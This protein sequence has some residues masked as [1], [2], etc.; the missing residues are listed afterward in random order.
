MHPGWVDT[1]ALPIAMP[2][3]YKKFKTELRT[4]E[5]GADTIVWLACKPKEELKTGEFYFDRKVAEKH[6]CVAF[7]SHSKK[8]VDSLFAQASTLS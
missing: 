3:F 5:Q 8:D 4:C 2:D 6:L 7:T 1:P